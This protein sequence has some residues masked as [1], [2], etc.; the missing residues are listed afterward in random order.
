M[1]ALSH[2]YLLGI[3][4]V[5]LVIGYLLRS[6]AARHDPMDLAKDAAWQVAKS[7]GK[8]SA[9][10]ESE[11][12]GKFK[13]LQADGSNTGRAKKAAGYAARHAAAQV[14]GICGLLSLLIGAVM[15]GLAFYL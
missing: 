2:P 13:E 9:V 12:A 6:W 4:V 5:L 3:G 7:K 15:I 10:N 8:L 14:A 11:L 1:S